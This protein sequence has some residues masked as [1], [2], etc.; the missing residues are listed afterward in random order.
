[1]TVRVENEGP[2]QLMKFLGAAFIAFALTVFMPGQ[3]DAQMGPD[4]WKVTGVASDDTLNIR[5]GPS[6]RNSVVARAPNGAIFRNLGC[7]GTG[8]DRWCHLE[9]PDGRVN[10]WAAGRFLAE[11]GAPNQGN[12]SGSNDVPELHVRNTGE[13]EVRYASGCT[14]LYNPAGRRI[15]AGSSCSQAQLSRAHDA[16]D[17][18]T[19]EQ[20]GSDNHS[21]GAPSADVRMSGSGLIS[22]DQSVVTGSIN[23]HAEGHYAL[24]LVGEGATCTGLLEHA[25]G[26]VGSE[27]TSIHCTNGA[28]GSAI[29]GQNGGLLTFSLTNGTA[30]FVKF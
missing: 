16:V 11:S 13:M 17:G 30:G 26:S 24:V 5:S 20:A 23:G 27:A 10:G 18:Y 7:R 28:H 8:T 1:M 19:R 2:E 9:T 3:A 6:T 21:A 14:V 29:L 15:S 25:P 12:I 22:N 4:Y